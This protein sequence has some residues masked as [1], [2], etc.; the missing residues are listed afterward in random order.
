MPVKALLNRP[1]AQSGT[2]FYSVSNM[3]PL[4]LTPKTKLVFKFIFGLAVWSFLMIGLVKLNND[5]MTRGVIPPASM[6]Q[7]QP[8]NSRL[9]LQK[10]NR[11]AFEGTPKTTDRFVQMLTAEEVLVDN[12][13]GRLLFVITYLSCTSAVLECCTQQQANDIISMTMITLIKFKADTKRKRVDVQCSRI[14]HLN[15]L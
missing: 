10:E 15:F 2:I 3:K 14:N 7:M 5:Q 11:W 4:S 8:I 1:S 12:R 9:L 13:N 6:Q